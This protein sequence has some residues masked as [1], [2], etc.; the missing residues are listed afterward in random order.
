MSARVERVIVCAVFNEIRDDV[1]DCREYMYFT[2]TGAY[3]CWDM[4]SGSSI[5]TSGCSE[6]EVNSRR[7]AAHFTEGVVSIEVMVLVDRRGVVGG[8]GSTRILM[9]V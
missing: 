1:A 4:M 8:V 6:T 2:A 9:S 3:D 7:H 5:P